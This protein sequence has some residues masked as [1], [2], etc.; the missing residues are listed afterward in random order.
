MNNIANMVFNL[1]DYQWRKYTVFINKR[2]RS[3]K[4]D[5]TR[6]EIWKDKFFTQIVKF[7]VP[8]GIISLISSIIVEYNN[9]SE[10]TA[11]IDT[12]AFVTVIYIMLHKKLSIQFK[13]LFGSLALVIFATLKIATL[14]SLLLGTIYL[15]LLSIIA[16]L[17]FNKRTAYLSIAVNALICIG[18]A[19]AMFLGFQ[20][21][22]LDMEN[23]NIISRWFLFIFNFTFANLVI[24]S[25]IIYI[26][27]G[28]EKTIEKAELFQLKLKNEISEKIA[29][30]LLLRESITHYKSMF[31]LNPLPMLIYDPNS[32]EFLQINRSAINCYGYTK[33]EFLAMKINQLLQMDEDSFKNT[34]QHGSEYQTGKH[35]HREGNCIIVDINESSIMLNGTSARLSIIRDITAENEYISA[36]EGK[37]E[38]MREIAYLQSHVIRKPLSSILG[39][40]NLLDMETIEDPD[41]KEFLSYLKISADELDVVISKIVKHTEEEIKKTYSIADARSRPYKKYS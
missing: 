27:D 24:V 19:V 5:R 37:N 14:N 33:R 31:L 30:E 8:T 13:K 32:L 38:K 15:L 35:Y 11:I 3:N 10:L 29:K 20:M 21:H 25:I 17:L 36:I 2:T 26:I 40:I 28:F 6:S 22:R 41:L 1:F 34:K 4:K 12:V 7:A 23:G 39:I 18:F 9:D 16:T